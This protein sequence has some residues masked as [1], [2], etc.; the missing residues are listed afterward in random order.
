MSDVIATFPSSSGNAVYK[1]TRGAD[2]VVWCD[3]PGHKFS[4]KG[5]MPRKCKHTTAL[6]KGGTI[7][8]APAIPGPPVTAEVRAAAPQAMLAHQVEKAPREPWGDPAWVMETKH[9]GWRLFL[10][11]DGEGRQLQ[12]ARSGA[13]HDEEWLRNLPLPPNTVV[14]GEVCAPGVASAYATGSRKAL[15]YVAFDVLRAGGMELIHEPWDVRRAALET[16]VEALD[17]PV[18]ETSKVLGVPNLAGAEWLMAAGAEGVMLKRRAAPYQPGKRSWDQL[19]AKWTDTYDVVVVDM[20]AEPTSTDRKAA[21]WKNLRYG[22]YIDG[23]LQVVGT[24]G[25]TGPPQELAKYIGKVVEVKGYG[26]SESTGA[27]RHP[28]FLKLRSDKLP[29]ECTFERKVA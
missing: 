15:V 11:V 26:Q 9:D 1:V 13:L 21:G 18:V 17:C 16:I 12:F 4:G 8:P 22:M 6:E 14:D 3:C 7:Q 29:Q 28:I 20:E 27:L 19:K 5:G 25:V 2:G 24:L 23:A 10:V